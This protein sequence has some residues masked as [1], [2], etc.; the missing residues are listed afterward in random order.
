MIP[1]ILYQISKLRSDF[2][3][4][5][6]YNLT[7]FC[8]ILLPFFV[9]CV[10]IAVLLYMIASEAVESMRKEQG[11]KEPEGLKNTVQIRL[12]PTRAQAHMLREHC[13]ESIDCVNTII[14][15]HNA[16]MIPNGFSTKPEPPSFM[17]GRSQP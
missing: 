10:M 14:S 5:K 4:G 11:P 9:N 7:L 6:R 12:Y 15:A 8:L 16:D 3:E 1:F 2:L 17:A 13:Q